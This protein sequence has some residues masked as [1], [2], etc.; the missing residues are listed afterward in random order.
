MN[1]ADS[2]LNPDLTSKGE[3]AKC[4]IECAGLTR[5]IES[6][7][8]DYNAFLET[9]KINNGLSSIPSVSDMQDFRNKDGAKF[10]KFIREDCQARLAD[11]RNTNATA[12]SVSAFMS[13]PALIGVFVKIGI[14]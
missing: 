6:V 7:Q 11:V 5:A 1:C 8:F 12:K 10:L 13:I 2:I 14:L 4:A 3:V 9:V